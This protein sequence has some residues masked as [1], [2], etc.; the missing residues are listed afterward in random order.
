MPG[1]GLSLE[2]SPI[3]RIW[4][5]CSSASGAAAKVSGTFKDSFN[6]VNQSLSLDYAESGALN[7]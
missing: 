2:S 4:W 7:A 6:F 3:G 5:P 1:R